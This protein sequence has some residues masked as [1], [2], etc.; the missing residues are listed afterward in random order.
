M[1]RLLKKLL[2]FVRSFF[3]I[4]WFLLVL[5]VSGWIGFYNNDPLSLNILGITLPEFTTGIYLGATFATGAIFGWFGTWLIARIKLFSRK[6]ELKKTKK[7]VE[8]LRI[9]NY[10]EG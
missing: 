4:A 8:K 6:R 2:R 5:V 9:A 10:Q 7:E 1:L 3:V